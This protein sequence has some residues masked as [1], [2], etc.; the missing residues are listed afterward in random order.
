[1]TKLQSHIYRVPGT[2]IGPIFIALVFVLIFGGSLFASILNFGWSLTQLCI[3]VGLVMWILR[4]CRVGLFLSEEGIVIRS[5]LFTRT[6]RYDRVGGFNTEGYSGTLNAFTQLSID[7][8]YR[9]TRM[10]T[11][12]VDGRWRE[13]PSTICSVPTAKRVRAE[14][15]SRVQEHQKSRRC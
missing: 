5:W 2:R 3:L 1:M 13:F 4:A 10:V 14:I 6:Y 8:F 11:L 7:P 15:D 9:Y 12:R